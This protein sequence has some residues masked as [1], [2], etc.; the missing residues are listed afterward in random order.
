MSQDAT[1]GDVYREFM[2]LAPTLPKDEHGFIK[3]WDYVVSLNDGK[4]TI[5]EVFR[6]EKYAVGD[7]FTDL[8]SGFEATVQQV[9]EAVYL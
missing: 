4:T 6:S 2:G 8:L 5:K 3:G 1:I 7:K 9:K